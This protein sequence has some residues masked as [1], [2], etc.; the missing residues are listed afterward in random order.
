MNEIVI[1]H[2]QPT[3]HHAHKLTTLHVKIIKSYHARLRSV[4][5]QLYVPRAAARAAAAVHLMRLLLR[6]KHNS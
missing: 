2:M 5:A 1:K 6:S 4:S 3:E